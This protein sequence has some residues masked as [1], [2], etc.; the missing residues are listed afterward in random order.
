MDVLRT[1]DVP[2]LWVLAADDR[3]APVATT[4]ERLQTLRGQGK[5]IRIVVYPNTDHGMREFVQADN[6][7]RE[8]TRITDTFYDLIADWARGTLEAEYAESY[9][10]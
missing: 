7:T 5:D 9:R 1:V 8:Y 10:P 2:Q 3:E 6:G 4:L